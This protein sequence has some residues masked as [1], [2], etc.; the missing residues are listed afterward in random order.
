M[1]KGLYSPVPFSDV[2]VTGPFWRERLETVL[3]RTIPS[4]HVKLAEADPRN[5]VGDLAC[6]E[7]L[8]A[9]R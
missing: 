2:A 7:F 4:Q 1:S 9:Q 6:D 3:S 8:A 5:C